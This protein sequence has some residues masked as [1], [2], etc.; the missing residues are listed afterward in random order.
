MIRS[1]STTGITTKGTTMG[2]AERALGLPTYTGQVEATLGFEKR[3]PAGRWARALGGTTP[4]HFGSLWITTI[5]TSQLDVH[6]GGGILLEHRGVNVPIYCFNDSFRC[7]GKKLAVVFD[8]EQP[9]NMDDEEFQEMADRAKSAGFDARKVTVTRGGRL[10]GGARATG[11]EVVIRALLPSPLRATDI[12]PPIHKASTGAGASI[13]D[14]NDDSD[15]GP[16]WMD[17]RC[18][19][20]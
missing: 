8:C 1:V 6:A 10:P 15:D 2:L 9:G 5:V 13:G 12:D 14:R 19:V 4:S 11:D 18:H 17:V 3:D 20:V 16:I 7:S